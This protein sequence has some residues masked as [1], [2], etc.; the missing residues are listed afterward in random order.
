MRAVV[1][2]GLHPAVLSTEAS[3][4][5]GAAGGAATEFIRSQGVDQTS[6]EPYV[7]Q[8]GLELMTLCTTIKVK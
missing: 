8:A 3:A 4:L 1:T 5:P 7:D 6:L 2:V